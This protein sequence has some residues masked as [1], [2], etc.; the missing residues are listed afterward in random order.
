[1]Q[2]STRGMLMYDGGK[3]E[4]VL[5][6]GRKKCIWKEGVPFLVKSSFPPLWAELHNLCD[7][8]DYV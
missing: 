6:Y 7:A 5:F 1:M 3:E 4:K 2:Q 8:A